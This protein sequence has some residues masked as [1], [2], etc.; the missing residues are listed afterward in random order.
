MTVRYAFPDIHDVRNTRACRGCG[1]RKSVAAFPWRKRCQQYGARCQ[2]CE[3]QRMR[4]Y[5]RRRPKRSRLVWT[6]ERNRKLLTL[7]IEGS[8]PQEAAAAIGVT[9]SAVKN[10]RFRMSFPPFSQRSNWRQAR[11]AWPQ[12]RIA[13]LKTLRD[14]GKSFSECA[15]RLGTTRNAIAHGTRYLKEDAHP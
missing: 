5:I 15:A 2:D 8:S 3:N 13:R 10:Q 7:I 6:E 12:S 9:K 11:P 14:R 1:E 4:E